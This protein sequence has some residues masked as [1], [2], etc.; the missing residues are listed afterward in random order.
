MANFKDS[1]RQEFARAALRDSSSSNHQQPSAISDLTL[2]TADGGEKS[3]K[4]D[5]GELGFSK[6]T[7][8]PEVKI[9]SP[10]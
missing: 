6:W 7:P 3:R 8:E 1:G 9:H 4:G 10:L 2:E 5:D